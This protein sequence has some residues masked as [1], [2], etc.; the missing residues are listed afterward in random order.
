MEVSP[1]IAGGI[2]LL[3]AGIGFVIKKIP[4]LF[5][6]NDYVESTV[7]TERHKT[8]DKRLD[9]GNTLMKELSTSLSSIDKKLAVLIATHEQTKQG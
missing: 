5:Q 3:G 4:F 8:I 2:L 6:T 7:C 9:E 1:E